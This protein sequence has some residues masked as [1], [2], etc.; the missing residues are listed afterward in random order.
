MSKKIKLEWVK[1]PAFPSTLTAKEAGYQ[2][3]A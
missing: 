3:M 1:V 2:E